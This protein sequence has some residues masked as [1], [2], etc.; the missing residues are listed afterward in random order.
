MLKRKFFQGTH[1]LQQTT[2]KKGQSRRYVWI[3]HPH[4]PL[5][6][7]RVQAVEKKGTDAASQWV[8]QLDDQTRTRIPAS[9]A[10]PDDG[11]T[12][13]PPV[14]C[15]AG[16]WAD[17]TGLLRLARMVHRLNTVLPT[18]GGSD[19]PTTK[20]TAGEAGVASAGRNAAL[21]GQAATGTET[22][23]DHSTDG[24][25]GQMARRTAP[26]TGGG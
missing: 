25:D 23:C 18:E 22:D 4:H 6:G 1:S 26:S 15:T 2:P 5:A 7:R 9:W 20:D 21:L 11:E 10:V 19:E 16:P 12:D 14:L 24:H 3:V 8:I 13:S 17:V